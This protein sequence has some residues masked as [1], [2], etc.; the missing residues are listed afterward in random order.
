M[1]YSIISTVVLGA[2]TCALGMPQRPSNANGVF[3][4]SDDFH[5]VDAVSGNGKPFQIGYPKNATE[6]VHSKRLEVGRGG[7]ES[8]SAALTARTG[9]YD[10]SW[11]LGTSGSVDDVPQLVEYKLSKSSSLFYD[12]A[13]DV[14]LTNTGWGADYTFY[15]ASPDL[16]TLTAFT[17]GWHTVRYNSDNPTI[18]HVKTSQTF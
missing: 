5:W 3:L 11:P 8:T 2:M 7:E 14:K 18:V 12:Y 16:Y 10:V 17:N 15:D 13:L 1:R 9:T 4:R 6:E